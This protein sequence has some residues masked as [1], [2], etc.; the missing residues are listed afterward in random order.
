V[1]GCAVILP[2]LVNAVQ[3]GRFYRATNWRTSD[4]NM[5]GPWSDRSSE[6]QFRNQTNAADTLRHSSLGATFSGANTVL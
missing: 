5:R 3:P 4:G 6:T 1:E 2:E